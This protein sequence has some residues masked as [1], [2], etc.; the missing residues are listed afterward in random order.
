[1]SSQTFEA[2]TKLLVLC[3]ALYCLICSSFLHLYHRDIAVYVFHFF[4]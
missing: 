1:M 2:K 4:C 3:G